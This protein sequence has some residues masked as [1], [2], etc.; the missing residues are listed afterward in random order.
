MAVFSSLGFDAELSHFLDV[1]CR[2]WKVNF[3]R[4]FSKCYP[5]TTVF[6]PQALQLFRNFS[7]SADK[8]TVKTL[9]FWQ[10]SFPRLYVSFVPA[11]LKSMRISC[12]SSRGMFAF[13][14]ITLL[15]TIWLL[16]LVATRQE[17]S[18]FFL[19]SSK[20]NLPLPHRLC[21]AQ[22]MQRLRVLYFYCL[23]YICW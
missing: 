19:S 6:H 17:P 11:G 16:S 22:Y 3:S 9:V 14:N 15:G 5:L 12:W 21:A 13:N 2:S 7:C 1:S 10:P 20:N 4:S 23:H 8:V 18:V